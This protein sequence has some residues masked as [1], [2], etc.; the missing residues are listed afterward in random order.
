MAD[1]SGG[2][3]AVVPLS[4]LLKGD[5][6]DLSD[7][8]LA[9]RIDLAINTFGKSDLAEYHH[10]LGDDRSA[11]LAETHPSQGG[12]K[13]R[14]LSWHHNSSKSVNGEFNSLSQSDKNHIQEVTDQMRSE[15]PAK[16]GL[17]LSARHGVDIRSDFMHTAYDEW[18]A[19]RYNPRIGDTEV[20]AGGQELAVASPHDWVMAVRELLT[21]YFT[22]ENTTIWLKHQASGDMH[23]VDALLRWMPEKQSQYAAQ[24]DAWMR[25][26]CGGKRP[27]GG[28]TEATYDDPYISLI[29]LTASGM[30]DGEL[31]SPCD[32]MLDLQDAWSKTYHALKNQMNRLG[33][34]SDEW[35]YER[36]SEPHT[37]KRGGGIN[38]GYAHEHIVLITDG[39]VTQEDLHP[40]T[41]TH[42]KHCKHAS[43]YGHGTSSIEVKRHD[44]L[45]DAA[46][47]VA[48]YCAISVTD[49]RDRSIPY[50]MFAASAT[51]CGY[52]TVSRSQ[53]TLAAI[54]ADA[55]KQRY[56]SDK[57]LQSVDHGEKVVLGQYGRIVCARCQSH[58][59]IDQR[60][61]LSS[62]RLAKMDGDD[63]KQPMSDGGHPVDII[64]D[65][66]QR[67]ADDMPTASA[68]WKSGESME[69]AA[70]RKLV[71]QL[72]DDYVAQHGKPPDDGYDLAVLADQQHIKSPPH[73][74]PDWKIRIAISEYMTDVSVV[75]GRLTKKRQADAVADRSVMQAFKNRLVD[76]NEALG[77][78]SDVDELMRHVVWMGIQDPPDWMLAL[79]RHVVDDDIYTGGKVGYR[80]PWHNPSDDRGWVIDHVEVFG[81][82]RPATPDGGVEYVKT[83]NWLD[84]A[85]PVI[86]SGK[87]YE[88]LR[89]GKKASGVNM[90]D[91]MC[92]GLHD[93]RD[94]RHRIRSK[95]VLAWMVYPLDSETPKSE[96]VECAD[97]YWWNKECVCGGHDHVSDETDGWGDVEVP[98]I[99]V[100]I[101]QRTIMPLD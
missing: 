21:L 65:V 10:G 35:C 20:I 7:A 81:E 100:S 88:C 85:K 27:S 52:R 99:P 26:F 55:C 29:T 42:V 59:E 45:T 36:R 70:Y 38:T 75:V 83:I 91:H 13:S 67:F 19:W 33:F 1:K 18:S 92:G 12:E 14:L 23:G 41:Q 68:G 22:A 16:S 17:P 78:A 84:W 9:E 15:Y 4:D 74:P 97:R 72:M 5:T 76:T 8:E 94:K 56:E 93:G 63:T 11:L 31:A 98:D 101:T 58:H 50:L 62:A 34:E 28:V 43:E 6:S 79:M 25:E 40:V 73:R 54:K 39:K 95:N 3:P 61:T 82:R 44:E 89:C 32:H 86:E 96:Y 57:S 49:I 66:R 64:S 37:G 71:R 46:S 2:K 53:A 69:K 60:Q 30:P 48:D 24:L 90:A 87:R 47:Y 80:R 51:A 77:G